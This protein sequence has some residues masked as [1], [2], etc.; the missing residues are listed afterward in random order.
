MSSFKNKARTFAISALV[1][2]LSCGSSG[3]D[4]ALGGDLVFVAVPSDREA[5]AG[6]MSEAISLSTGRGLNIIHVAVAVRDRNGLQILD[7]SPE[8]GVR[9]RPLRQFLDDFRFADGTPA[10]FIIK[11][12]KGGFD[13]D[14]AILRACSHLGKDYDFAYMPT[15]EK[16]YCSELIYESYL[17]SDGEHVFEAAPMNF[18]DE[19][20]ELP[21]YWK[22]L[23]GKPGSC[24]PQGEAG[25]NPAD[26]FLSDRLET[27]ARI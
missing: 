5:A 12:V 25:T 11:R 13:A 18:L 3:W 15:D 19:N 26:M 17:D 14:A 4:S 21:P 7:A 27:V 16:L 20:G 10:E 2:A 1:S 9:M 6:S 23:F 8:R 24:V 22:E